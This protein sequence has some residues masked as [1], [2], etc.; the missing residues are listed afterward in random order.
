MGTRADFYIRKDN[1]MEWLGSI[2]WDGYPEGIEEAVIS[3]KN[4]DDFRYA[5]SE[6]FKR[7]DVTLPEHGWPWPWDDSKTTDYSYIFE[8]GKVMASC[9]GSPLFDPLSEYDE[10]EDCVQK[11]DNYFP[12]M[13]NIKKLTLGKRSGL[14][15][16]EARQ[17]AEQKDSNFV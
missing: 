2:G 9:F 15:V 12:D 17:D 16:V 6:F 8:N 5:L 11:M 3:A 14:I 1:Q 4:E 13:K 10:G 7:D